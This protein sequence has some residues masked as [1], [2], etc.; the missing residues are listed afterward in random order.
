MNFEDVCNLNN[1]SLNTDNN[2]AIMVDYNNNEWLKRYNVACHWWSA[3]ATS[4]HCHNFYEFFIVTSGEAYHEINNRTS[5]LHKGTLRLITP[6]DAHCIVSCKGSS[7]T[8]INLSVTVERLEAICTSLGVELDELCEDI[9]NINLSV[10]ELEFFVKTA[11]RVS[12]M[13]F[14]NDDRGVVF[15]SEMLSNAVCIIYNYKLFSHQE[16]PEWF[17]HT[18]EKIHSPEY[19]SC[20]ADDIYRIAGF[21]APVVIDRFKRY[22]GKTVVEYLKMI[23]INNACDMLKNTE[24]SILEISNI[25]GYASLSHFNRVFKEYIGITPALYR[26]ENKPSLINF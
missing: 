25:I 9:Q 14:N 19:Y 13:Q 22:T 6:N 26:K 4:L 16:R 12:L 20:S 5:R 15:I 11:Q 24:T 23:K 21:S 3:D 7:C 2:L 18:L 10:S 8:H 17:T 1:N